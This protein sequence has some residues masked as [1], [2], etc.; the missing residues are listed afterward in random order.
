[1]RT[2]FYVEDDEG[3]AD[4][5]RAYLG[6]RGYAV[7][8]LPNAGEATEALAR[9]TPSLC[10]VDWNLP[11]ET[12]EWLC[13]WIRSRWVDLPILFLTVNDQVNDIVN[14]FRVGADDYVT[15]PFELEVL[16]SRICAILRR[17]GDDGDVMTCGGVTVDK[18]RHKVLLDGVEVSLS[19]MEYQLL[20]ILMENK[21]R[22]VTRGRLF[23]T[24]WDANGNFVNDNTLTVTMKRLR[25][26]LHNPQSVK[27]I[28]SF[29][30]RMEDV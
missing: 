1:M 2:I 18:G 26:K 11:D 20:L 30:Y 25:E 4:S 3:I 27:T 13:R 15:K 22:T 29:G 24:I 6:E 28:R 7:T 14:G 9:Q 21:N 12:G 19:G 10:L 5:V 17:A 16:Y 8:V 23:E